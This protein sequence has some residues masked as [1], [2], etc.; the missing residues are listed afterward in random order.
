MNKN[1]FYA[2]VLLALTLLI[3][4]PGIG[5]VNATENSTTGLHPVLL[6]SGQPMPPPVPPIANE[7]LLVASGQPMPPPVPPVIRQS[8]PTAS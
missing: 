4:L 5:A 1:A 2:F 8:V 7:S 3:V 6:A